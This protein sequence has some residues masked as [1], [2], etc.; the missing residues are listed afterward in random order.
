[1]RVKTAFLHNRSSRLPKS[2]AARRGTH[3]FPAS[4]SV[5]SLPPS[6]DRLDSAHKRNPEVPHSH[7]TGQILSSY[8]PNQY[9]DMPAAYCLTADILFFVPDVCVSPEIPSAPPGRQKMDGNGTCPP[10]SHRHFRLHF[11]S[12]L[13][14]APHA[15][16][17]SDLTVRLPWRTPLPS[18]KA[19]LPHA[20]HRRQ[21]EVPAGPDLKFPPAEGPDVQQTRA[22]ASG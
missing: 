20:P 13:P 7:L 5:L 21:S 17:R 15:P 22:P 19:S 10:P 2:P 11:V 12:L 8:C 14:R 6:A 9:P 16:S 1:M 4:Q 3:T 18:K